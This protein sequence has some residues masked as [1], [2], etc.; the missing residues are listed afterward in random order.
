MVNYPIFLNLELK[1]VL[2]VGGG[3]AAYEKLPKLI[4]SKA[5]ITIISLSLSPK[6]QGLYE[7]HPERITFLNRGIELKDLDNFFM[8]FCATNNPKKN[9]ELVAYA[10]KKNLL[11]NSVDD[12]S[13]CDFFSMALLKK[14]KLTLGFSTTGHFAGVSVLLKEVFDE[15]IPEGDIDLW[16]EL[17][18]LRQDLKKKLEPEKRRAVLLKVLEDLKKEYFYEN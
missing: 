13:N 8:I 7:K 10:R 16:M 1:D 14:D 4:D 18:R 6:V 9:K 15:L 5:N 3:L 2:V 12:P 17:F 11:I